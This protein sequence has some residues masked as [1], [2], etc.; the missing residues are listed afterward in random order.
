MLKVSEVLSTRIEQF[1]LQVIKYKYHVQLFHG[2]VSDCH[3]IL[4]NNNK[5]NTIM[6]EQ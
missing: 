4:N 6:F 3:A 2:L 1:L 5:K